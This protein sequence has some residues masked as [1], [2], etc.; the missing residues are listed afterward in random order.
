MSL[1][2]LS[3]IFLVAGE[4][5]IENSLPY[6]ELGIEEIAQTQGMANPDFSGMTNDGAAYSMRASSA[7]LREDAPDVTDIIGLTARIDTPSDVSIS[8]TAPEARI[9]NRQGRVVLGPSTLETT[10]GYSIKAKELNVSL[11]DTEIVSSRAV[12]AQGPAGTIRANALSLTRMGETQILQ[13][14]GGVQM[15]YHPPEGDF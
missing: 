6:R 5:D 13:F 3:G 14:T 10:D 4:V 11:K 9:D 12:T 7:R 1:V 2:G 15:V 8:V